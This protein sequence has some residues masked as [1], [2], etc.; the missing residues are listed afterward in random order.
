MIPEEEFIKIFKYGFSIKELNQISLLDLKKIAG[1]SKIIFS[2]SWG[3]TELNAQEFMDLYSSDK[4]EKHLN[5]LYLLYKGEEIIG[6]C[7]TSEENKDTIICKTICI[8]PEYQGLGLGNAIAYKVHLDAKKN[9]YKKIIYALIRE[10]N[11]IKNFPKDGTVIFRK[12]SA[13]DY[14]I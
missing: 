4:L 13:F 11:N 10:T 8:L 2:K 9:G 12:Y 3:Y 5:S 6:F 1:I 14:K 7:S